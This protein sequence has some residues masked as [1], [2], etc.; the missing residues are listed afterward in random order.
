MIL[1]D[2]SI[3]EPYILFF[4]PE[5][6]I[7][8]ARAHHRCNGGVTGRGSTVTFSGNAVQLVHADVTVALTGDVLIGRRELCVTAPLS[9][10]GG[11]DE[12]AAAATGARADG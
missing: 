4:K 6:R 5:H 11:Q 1:I 10:R 9:A 12:R 3:E 7:R 2:E 8:V